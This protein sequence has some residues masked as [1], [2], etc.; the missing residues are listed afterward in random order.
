MPDMHRGRER[1]FYRQFPREPLV[2]KNVK[3]PEN[4]RIRCV[5]ATDVITPNL[6]DAFTVL[7]W[8]AELMTRSRQTNQF[9]HSIG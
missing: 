1:I 9:D 2:V 5:L 6:L 8:L 4:C 7:P 3:L